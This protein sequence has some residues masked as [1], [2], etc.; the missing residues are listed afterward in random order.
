MI[1]L[2]SDAG[3]LHEDKEHDHYVEEWWDS[4]QSWCIQVNIDTKNIFHVAETVAVLIRRWS[5][6]LM[7]QSWSSTS[8]WSHGCSVAM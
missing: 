2:L 8:G 5:R 1:S 6:L 3:G 4:V 7:A